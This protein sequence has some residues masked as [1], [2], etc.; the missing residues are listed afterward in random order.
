MSTITAPPGIS[1][2]DLLPR[3]MQLL[4]RDRWSRDQLL[5]YQAQRLRALIA[6]A[7]SASPYYREVLGPAAASGDVPLKELP[8]LSKTALLDDFDRIVTDPRLRRAGVEAHVAGPDPAQPLHG[9]YQVFST[10]G[11][12]GQRG[13]LVQSRD[14]FLTAIASCVAGTARYG[15]TPGARIVGIG[16][17]SPFHISRQIGQRIEASLPS[18][19]Q[20]SPHLTATT[21]LPKIVAA[22]NSYQ[23]QVLISYSSFAALLAEAQIQ[24]ELDITPTQVCCAGEVLTGD[25]RHRIHEAWGL[26]PLQGYGATE[27]I[28]IAG[29]CPEHVGMHIWE[30][31]VVLEAVDEHNRPVPPG[32]PS[33]KV[34]LTNLVNTTQPLIRYELSDSV[35]LAAGPNP[36]GRPYQRI[37][38]VDGRS[39]DI[40]TLPAPG[41]GTVAVHPAPLRA[42]FIEFP[43]VCQYQICH[44]GTRLD[45][46]VVLRACA[47][48]DTLARVRTA[49]LRVIESTGAIPPRVD[50]TPVSV[51]EREAG[52]AAKFKLV[53][54][55]VCPSSC[56][57][58]SPSSIAVPPEPRKDG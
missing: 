58:P 35:T 40:L 10:S 2:A 1:Q 29:S 50:V 9:E 49:L 30:D 28:A 17:S 27:A 8:T 26:Q 47:A 51:I 56:P 55:T 18:G 23:P 42:P 15:V 36:T 53:R 43:D 38:R 44:D 31:L 33:H 20:V 21:P 11:T 34:L 41:G 16:S 3:V 57:T 39:D 6:H 46:R 32:T 4:A 25:M 54:S 13:L 37:D 12:T 48:P 22:L 7:V 45:V 19:G 52:A 14:E 5:T 24:G